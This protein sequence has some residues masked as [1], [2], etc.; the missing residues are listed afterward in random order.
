MARDALGRLKEAKE[1][2]RMARDMARSDPGNSKRL[3]DAARAK[4]TSA[5]KQ[6]TRRPKKRTNADITRR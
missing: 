1:L 6:L 4:R 3:H 2:D 5:V